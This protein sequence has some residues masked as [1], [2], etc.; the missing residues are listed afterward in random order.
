LRR[1]KRVKCALGGEEIGK[2][3]SITPEG[4]ICEACWNDYIG[5]KNKPMPIEKIKKERKKENTR[6]EEV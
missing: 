6:K 1:G 5:W 3:F 4:P 2:A